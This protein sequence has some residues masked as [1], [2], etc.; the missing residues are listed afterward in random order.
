M[1]KKDNKLLIIKIINII[2]ILIALLA[3]V[4]AFTQGARLITD[5][6][7][8]ITTIAA[9]LFALKYTV[10]GYKKEDIKTFN[11]FIYLCILT[12]FLQLAGE[13][14]YLIVIGLSILKSSTITILTMLIENILLIIIV[15]VKNME[16]K[17]ALTF[18]GTIII[19]STF[20]FC[21]TLAV[22]SY[23]ANYVSLAFSAIV[24]SFIIYI[25]VAA[26]YRSENL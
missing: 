23:S 9:L 19:F 5:W 16:K 24:L 22:F 4:Y 26:K 17:A 20:T 6:I 11:I 7:S 13:A 21:R 3:N 10:K 8:L 18:A 1:N 25:S 12:L 2:L 15:T 14:Y